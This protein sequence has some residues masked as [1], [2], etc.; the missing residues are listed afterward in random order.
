MTFYDLVRLRS[1]V[2]QYDGRPIP[3]EVLERIVET[4]RL[5]PSAVNSQPWHFIIVDDPEVLAQ[6]SATLVT[7]NMNKFASK[8]SAIIVLVEE[9]MN[10]VSRIGGWLKSK[11]Y[12]HMDLGIAAEHIALAATEEGIGSCIIGWL[13]EKRMRRLLHIPGS[14]RIPVVVAL[15]YAEL[16]IKEKNRKPM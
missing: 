9:P 15:G 6:V 14:K 8:A 12:A 16:T 4:A 1:S 5:A 10:I 11:H 13:D 2:R 7:G 3:R